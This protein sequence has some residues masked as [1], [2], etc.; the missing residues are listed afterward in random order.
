MQFQKLVHKQKETFLPERM[1]QI[2]VT[3]VQGHIFCLLLSYYSDSSQSN[4]P[5]HPRIQG[6]KRRWGKDSKISLKEDI[7]PQLLFKV[8]LH[9]P[10]FIQKLFPFAKAMVNLHQVM[11]SIVPQQVMLHHSFLLLLT[12]ACFVFAFL[13][14]LSFLSSILCPQNLHYLPAVLYIGFLW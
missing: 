8:E 12:L 4:L 1:E 7:E 5:S 10:A 3:V 6:K 9:V 11:S 2:A 14:F 13:V